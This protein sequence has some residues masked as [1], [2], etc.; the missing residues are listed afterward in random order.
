M[1]PSTIEKPSLRRL[2]SAYLTTSIIW[3]NSSI[4]A[5]CFIGACYVY[6]W[7][8]PSSSANRIP[9]AAFGRPRALRTLSPS[10]AIQL[11]QEFDNLQN[12]N[13]YR[14]RPWVGF[15]ERPFSSPLF[16]VDN[17][18]PLPTRRTID[19]P[20]GAPN[21]KTIWLF[22]GSTQFGWGVPDSQTIA[23]HLSAILSTART[24]YNVVNHGH[25]WF[26][27]S[28]ESALFTTLLR[29]GQKCDIAVFLDGYNDNFL[30]GGDV[31]YLTDRTF[32]AFLKEERTAANQIAVAPSF[33]PLRILN[34][35]LRWLPKPRPEEGRSEGVH[36]DPVHI[37]WFN[38]SAIQKIAEAE[39]IGVAF[40]WQPTPFD[41]I[42]GAEK[43]RN[44]ADVVGI[45]GL[46]LSVRRTIRNSAFHF[47]ADLFK[48]ENYED[49]YVD[50]VHYGDK[51]SR[52]VAQAIAQSLKSDGLLR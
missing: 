47:M 51:G 52:L 40:Y 43:R 41:Y 18:E 25:T 21:T 12:S 8:R 26:Y 1:R 2:K 27:S 38:M 7:I 23:S 16:N 22:G 28:Q 3:L 48:G 39:S 14:Y 6:T 37:Y 30:S 9:Y 45:P 5:L 15:S 31:P 17:A 29:H 34:R 46:N 24:H 33:P 50:G 10:A 36:Y 19:S 32:T 35:L 42:P 49:I 44:D 13:E 20:D 11:F 4:L